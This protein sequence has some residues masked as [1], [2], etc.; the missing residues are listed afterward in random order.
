MLLSLSAEKVKEW[1]S[2]TAASLY[3]LLPALSSWVEEIPPHFCFYFT[4]TTSEESLS[5]HFLPSFQK[6][7]LEK[8]PNEMPFRTNSLKFHVV[9]CYSWLKI[10]PAIMRTCKHC[11]CSG[12]Q[13]LLI[14]LPRLSSVS[15]DWNT[16]L[17]MRYLVWSEAQSVLKAVW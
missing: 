13:T 10:W 4:P 11:S 5:R 16:D 17:I 12:W 9:T 8:T 3:L 15:C 7:C 2:S 1:F 14:R 6:L